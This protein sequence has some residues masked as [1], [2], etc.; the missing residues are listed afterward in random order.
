MVLIS[1]GNQQFGMPQIDKIV[2]LHKLFRPKFEIFHSFLNI[3][4]QL[5][6]E[7]KGHKKNTSISELGWSIPSPYPP[8]QLRIIVVLHYTEELKSIF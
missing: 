4:T 8:I 3:G 5:D 6:I 1:I 2:F 7:P